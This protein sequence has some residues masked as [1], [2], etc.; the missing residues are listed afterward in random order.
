MLRLAWFWLTGAAA[1]Q[2][3]GMAVAGELRMSSSA[4]KAG[5]PRALPSPGWAQANECEIFPQVGCTVGFSST[6]ASVVAAGSHA[7]AHFC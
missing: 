2:S 1:V 5:S 6:S 7:R 4:F 3:T